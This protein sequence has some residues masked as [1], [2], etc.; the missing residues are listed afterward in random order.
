MI[1]SALCLVPLVGLCFVTAT[2]SGE[3]KK[4]APVRKVEV[5]QGKTLAIQMT[6][7][8]PIRTI[9]GG[10]EKIIHIDPFSS[11]NGTV[12]RVTGLAPGTSRLALTDVDG[13]QETV[14]V[15]V[16]SNQRSISVGGSILLQMTTKQ[17]IKTIT[18]ERD[19]VARVLPVSGDPTSVLVIGRAP[20][21]TRITLVGADGKEETLEMGKPPAPRPVDR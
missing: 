18:N 7:R 2:A 8:R 9:Q 4:P 17:P 3:E 15:A 20:G 12:V 1:R 10:D 5:L 13:K 11:A 6:T 21:R 16:L 14:E 19:D